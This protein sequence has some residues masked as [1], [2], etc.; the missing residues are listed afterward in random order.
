[1]AEFIGLGLTHYPP[2][3]WPDE[4]MAGLLR[5]TLED[6]D[7]PNDAKDPAIWSEQMQEEWRDPTVAASRHRQVLTDNLR[8]VRFRLEAFDPDVVIV[9]GDDQYENFRESVIP[10]FA[11]LA[12]EDREEKP[13]A[14]PRHDHP[15]VWDEP[16]D[17]SFFIRSDRETAK[18]LVTG[19]ITRHFDLAYA[20]EPLNQDVLPHAFLNTVLFLDYDRQG[21]PWPVIPFSVNCYGNRVISY[22]GSLSRFADRGRP[23]DPPGP[24]PARCM[25]L[26]AAVVDTLSDLDLKVALVASASWS[27]AFLV[28]KTWRLTPAT[29]ADRSYYD[30]M[31]AGDY[32]A[33]RRAKTEELV[34][35]GQQEMLNWFCLLGAM[36]ALGH[37]PNWSDFV[38]TSIFN[39]NKV[40]AEFAAP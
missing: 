37:V 38:E 39:S 18:R 20:Y 14:D 12:Y 22:R 33:L 5:W 10:T 2:L 36:E 4:Q 6:P 30:H 3:A 15:N 13:W 9:W 21:F 8:K 11:V 29:Q 27:H 28:D 1:M 19:L 7:I 31:V 17:A 32:K 24:S 40:F 34:E 25:S 16:K 26:G 35:N 23:L